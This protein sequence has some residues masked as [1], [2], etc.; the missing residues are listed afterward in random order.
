VHPTFA[1]GFQKKFKNLHERTGRDVVF[2]AATRAPMNYASWNHDA[3]RFKA[4]QVKL[5]QYLN[6]HA[7][8]LLVAEI[9]RRF[10]L[11]MSDLPAVVVAQE[12]WRGPWVVVPGIHLADDAAG[13][14]EGV[15]QLARQP[16]GPPGMGM[17]RL[18]FWL[19]KNFETVRWLDSDLLLRQ[20]LNRLYDVAAQL[21]GDMRSRQIMLSL[22]AGSLNRVNESDTDDENLYLDRAGEVA[23][24]HAAFDPVCDRL[25]FLAVDGLE[26]DSRIF[27]QTARNV[28]RALDA[29]SSTNEFDHTIA[30]APL[31]KAAELEFNLSVFQLLRRTHGIEMPSYFN[32]CNLNLGSLPIF[33][34]GQRFFL[35]RQRRDAPDKIEW[36]TLGGA[37]LLLPQTFDGRQSVEDPWR[38]ALTEVG[39]CD[40]DNLREVLVQLNQVRRGASHVVRLGL[41][42]ADA[43]RRLIDK[44]RLFQR[45][46]AIKQTLFSKDTIRLEAKQLTPVGILAGCEELFPKDPVELLSHSRGLSVRE[47]EILISALIDF[48]VH[49]IDNCLSLSAI[50]GRVIAALAS[51][52]SEMLEEKN[53]AALTHKRNQ[54]SDILRG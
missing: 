13:I 34:A 27:L 21:Q 44:S 7:S 47:R 36:P 52:Q 40:V 10:K 5:G 11:Q 2:F 24:A 51:V 18:R 25:N 1:D 9:G 53:T 4:E 48:K 49:A 6:P 26:S 41:S 30:V 37:H 33:V 23:I 22:L 28:S 20:S 39:E 19:E 45:F 42:E 14:L 29:V 31:W 38:T 8:E 50:L 17:N 46:V 12:L 16:Y 35:N 32:R 15:L 43:V 54:F 3:E